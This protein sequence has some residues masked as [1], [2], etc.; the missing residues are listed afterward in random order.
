MEGIFVA[1]AW[2]FW[3]VFIAWLRYLLSAAMMQRDPA[4]PFDLDATE[5]AADAALA[6]ADPAFAATLRPAGR[7]TGFLPDD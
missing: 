7:G 5:A 6:D 4:A 1:L 2:C 3:L